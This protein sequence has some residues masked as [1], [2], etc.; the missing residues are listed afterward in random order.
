L[1]R[2]VFIL[3]LLPA[4]AYSQGFKA[5]LR[6]N[7]ASLACMAAAGQADGWNQAAAHHY[8]ALDRKFGLND[9]YFNPAI[10]WTNKYKN[11]DPAQGA[12]FFG[13]DTFLVTGTDFYHATRGGQHTF[14][15]GAI[16]FKIGKRQRWYKYLIDAA[17][18]SLAYAA[19]FNLTYEIICK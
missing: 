6:N 5:Y 14:F 3:L 10:S 16:V 9:Q 18:Y 17:A 7:G 15:L 8:P 11:H 13:S 2:L 12:A 4:L 1:K 19:G